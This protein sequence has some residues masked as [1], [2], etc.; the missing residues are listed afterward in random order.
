MDTIALPKTGLL[1]DDEI[2][3]AGSAVSFST[4]E[5]RLNFLQPGEL[6][7]F[8][9]EIFQAS[10][11]IL[12]LDYRLDERDGVDGRRRRYKASALAQ[13]LRDLATESPEKDFPIVLHSAEQKLRQAFFPERTAHD[14]FD[15]KIIK[16]GGKDRAEIHGRLMGLVEGYDLLIADRRYDA[17]QWEI[18]GLDAARSHFIEH[19]EIQNQLKTVA[20]PHVLAGFILKSM[21]DRNSVLLDLPNVLARAGLRGV[22]ESN[23]KLIEA[24]RGRGAYT[25]VFSRGRPRWWRLAVDEQ[26]QCWLGAP[27]SSL[28]AEQRAE[29]LT[30]SLGYEFQPARSTWS[31]STQERY[32]H[33]CVVC[34]LPTHTGHSVAILEAGNDVLA[35]RRR[36][37]FD[38][39][40][41]DKH[42]KP[43]CVIDALDARVASDIQQN[44]L[45]RP[46]T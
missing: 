2:G 1:V 27:G 19:Q 3:A 26:L 37:C 33:S 34:H 24:L 38:C 36:L 25:G 11:A 9:Q 18:F 43:G 41:K 22:P 32:T 29:R 7:E 21:I 20:V 14:L 10:P 17:R 15:D 40:Q 28:T 39:L 8:S 30:R 45:A 46:T 31:G 13:Q 35:S 23:R 42:V 12:V 4:A 5:L 44:K 16:E 6:E